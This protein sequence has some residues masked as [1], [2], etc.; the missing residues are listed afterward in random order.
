VD[1]HGMPLRIIV[2]EGTA[3]DYTKA[4]ELIEDIHAEYLIADKGYSR[5]KF[6]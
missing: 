1:A 3:S 2:T 4:A 6:S 5:H